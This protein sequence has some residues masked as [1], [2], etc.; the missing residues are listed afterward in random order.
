MIGT[1]FFPP[2]VV[3][4]QNRSAP[5]QHFLAILASSNDREF[6]NLAC[7]FSLYL[8]WFRFGKKEHQQPF[9][10]P[11]KSIQWESVF[12]LVLCAC[13]RMRHTYRFGTDS[14]VIL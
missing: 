1:F 11:P 3:Y 9:F 2:S 5:S 12:E 4:V 14:I 6:R 8:V 13:I 7:F 10:S